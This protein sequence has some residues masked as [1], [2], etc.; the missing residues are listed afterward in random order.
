MNE[1]MDSLMW[2]A[3]RHWM[4]QDSLTRADV[5]KAKH[6]LQLSVFKTVFWAF[7]VGV[8]AFRRENPRNFLEISHLRLRARFGDTKVCRQASASLG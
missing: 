8:F 7:C 2:M 4:A 5:D 6:R 3:K 1:E